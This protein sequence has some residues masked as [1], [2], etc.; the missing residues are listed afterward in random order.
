MLL[1]LPTLPFT[2]SEVVLRVRPEAASAF[3]LTILIRACATARKRKDPYSGDVRDGR[4]TH[5]QGGH[6]G[7]ARQAANAGA[8][9]YTSMVD[10][11][12]ARQRRRLC[13]MGRQLYYYN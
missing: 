6:H 5:L 13:T 11:E 2:L 10:R 8:R 12:V 4:S 7:N 1:R 9:R 3:T